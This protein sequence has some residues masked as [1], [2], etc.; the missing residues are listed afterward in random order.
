[1]G[2]IIQE[3]HDKELESLS[4]YEFCYNPCIHESAPITISTHLTKEG[5]QKAMR[6]HKTKERKE[7]KETFPT[8]EEQKEC[9]FGR[10]ESWFINQIKIQK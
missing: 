7:C 2:E 3:F 6:K 9:P 10:Y 4:L 1:M 8:K 5:A